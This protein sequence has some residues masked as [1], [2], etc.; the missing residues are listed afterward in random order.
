MNELKQYR[1]MV[2][3]LARTSSSEV[4]GNS[5]TA[6]AQVVV[7]AMFRYGSGD[8]VL[9]T[10][11]ANPKIYGD[12]RVVNAAVD[13]LSRG[14]NSLTIIAEKSVADVSDQTLTDNDSFVGKL[15][16]VGGAPHQGWLIRSTS[17]F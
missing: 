10:G 12:D 11:S 8:A 2:E 9:F 7:E 15:R 3:V 1:E 4:I 16:S 13:F 6:H 17:I 5:S 14:G